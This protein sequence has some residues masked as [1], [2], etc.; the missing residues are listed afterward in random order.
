M[1]K[2]KN[3]TKI[4]DTN[5]FK[6]NAL[7]DVSINF[8]KSEFAS[9]LGPSGSGKTT[10][11][12][13]VGGLDKYDSGDLI[14]NGIST[15]N[16][17]DRDWDTY[18]NHRVGFVFQSYN[19]ITHQTILQNVELA[20]T[21]SGVN[22]K[23]RRER[24]ITALETVGL[25]D[26]IYK[27][28]NQ[29]SGGQMQRVAIARALINDPD[30]ILADEPTGALD[31]ETSVQIME[32]LKSIS[33]DKLII[34]VTH[35]PELAETYSS[36]IIR[37]QDGIVLNDT[38]PY[39]GEEIVED[40]SRTKDKNKKTSMNFFT[41]LSLSTKNLISKKGRTILTSV[42]G[43]IGIIGIALI[44]SISTGVQDYI[45]S[46]QED[47]LSSYPIQLMSEQTD[48]SAL[49]A[50][51]MGI[52]PEAE[53]SEIDEERTGVY[54]N[55]IM[56]RMMKQMLNAEVETNNLE[57]FK[58]YMD[59]HKEEFTQ[60]T[61]AIQYGYDI[62]LNIYATDPNGEYAKADFIDLVQ[63]IIEGGNMMSGITSVME[64]MA[65]VNIW[66][67]LITDPNTGEISSLITDQYDLLHGKWP[68]EANEI[69][70]V[71]TENNE[72]SDITLY[73]LGLV[74]RQT[75]MNSSMAAMTGKE[76]TGW[77]D[78]LGRSWTYDEICNIPLKIILPT[79]YYRY[80]ESTKLWTDISDNQALLDSVIDKGFELKVAGI[81]RPKED[82]MAS[83]LTG[84]LCYTS[85]LSEWY[86][87]E[88]NNQEMI[89]QQKESDINVITGLP[90]ILEDE[91]ELTDD[92]K[93]TEFKN[94]VSELSNLEKA[95]LYES[96]LATPDETFVQDTIDSLLSQYDE[97]T[98]EDIVADIT[99]NYAQQLGY[100]G[101]LIKDMLSDYEKEELIELL[102]TTV[103]EMIASKSAEDASDEIE[104]IQGLPSDEELE[105]IKDMIL[106]E[107]YSSV[108]EIPEP[109][110]TMSI[111][112][113]NVGVIAQSWSDSTGIS[114]E[115]AAG[116]LASLST[117]QFNTIFDNTIN[118]M[119]T[120]MYAQYSGMS[121]GTDNTKKVAEAFD[122]YIEDCTD[123]DFIFYYENNMPEKVSDLSKDDLLDD[124]GLK[125]LDNPSFINI[126]P[127]DFE[128]KETIANMI[129]EYNNSVEEDDQIK[130]TDIVAMLMSSV[131]NIINA[132]S[133]VLIC[134]VSI[135]LIVSSIMIGIITYISV[136]ERT[137]EIGIL[138]AVGASKHDVSRVFNAETV[139]VGFLAGIVGVVATVLICIPMN[140]IARDVTGITSLTAVLPWY[141]YLLIVLSVVLTLIAGLFPAMMA[142]KK[143]PVEALRTE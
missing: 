86:I 19:L 34:M 44:L 9:I 134:F 26:H 116:Y 61:N 29:L 7:N 142:A 136:L 78:Y 25:K 51:M 2:L 111:M 83:T 121:A 5:G 131:S 89:K 105:E 47:T 110:K 112:Q 63:N 140:I 54:A 127:I 39:E 13:I 70:L 11:L 80:D 126:Y 21:L 42:A 76:D 99:K 87:K 75:M 123:E 17:K 65:G 56:Y 71:L 57:K 108:S 40:V 8:R 64:N 62:D 49:M 139:I 125:T 16:Y 120:E 137:K 97:K 60:Y 74:D 94:Y 100:S 73:A 36:R 50:S 96:I 85:A 37:V 18:R 107:M 115:A 14:I 103:R 35:N 143:D 118:A 109:Q 82:I 59:E 58:K 55:P 38:N 48:M 95:T 31:T 138:R 122:K 30:I 24:A 6:Q 22:K 45:D 106:K 12:N 129:T 119:A 128:M 68:T 72:I 79:D 84:S 90:F 132:I 28:P 52:S 41:A 33:K 117:E 27:K 124:L 92:E 98:A 130:Y 113:I 4:Y 3:I 53:N 133:V 101:E 102:E 88:I 15:K 91:K 20:L 141:G 66:Q 81:V 114:I 10:L 104:R 135:S 43:S 69:L 67:E 77:D 23:E 1:L 93:I 32:L 46:V